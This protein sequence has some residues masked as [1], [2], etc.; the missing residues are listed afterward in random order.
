MTGI[1]LIKEINE[2]YESTGLSLRTSNPSF[3][4]F[5][6]RDANQLTVNHYPSHRL[7]FFILIISFGTKSLNFTLNTTTFENVDHFIVCAAPGQ[8]MKWEKN[9]D[10][11]GFCLCFKSDFT[12]YESEMNLLEDFPFFNIKQ[13]N[14]FPINESEFRDLALNCQQIVTEQA[15]GFSYNSQIMRALLQAVLWQVRRIYEGSKQQPIEKQS[16][17][18]A[19]QFHYLVNKHFIHKTLVADYADMLNIT[20]NH[21]SQTIKAATGKTAKSIV[22]ERRLEEAKYLLRFTNNDISEIA[23]HLNFAEPTHF[24]K[25][26]K[27]E[28][29]S[30]PLQYRQNNK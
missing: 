3:H 12:R 21:L 7:D 13:T 14:L 6:M 24:T 28:V 17:I 4:I 2:A 20:A 18:L 10:W 22:T 1:P 23:F 27:K 25:L 16:L 26:F 11:F 19:S 29:Q 5:D 30:T 15:N 9:D 8:V